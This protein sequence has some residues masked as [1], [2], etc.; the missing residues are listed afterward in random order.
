M[1]S[2]KTFQGKF[3]RNVRPREMEWTSASHSHVVKIPVLQF[4]FLPNHSPSP[5]VK[6]FMQQFSRWNR[7]YSFLFVLWAQLSFKKQ[8]KFITRALQTSQNHE[9]SFPRVTK[10]HFLLRIW[11]TAFYFQYFVVILGEPSSASLAFPGYPSSV[12]IS[13]F[14]FTLF[15]L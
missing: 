9:S 14:S 11:A 13:L 15:G 12:F 3:P 5:R 8:K 2:P 10:T 4:S 7:F 1:F 6:F